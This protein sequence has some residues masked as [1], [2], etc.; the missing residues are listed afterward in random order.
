MVQICMLRLSLKIFLTFLALIFSAS[1]GLSAV[2]EC[3]FFAKTQPD[4]SSGLMTVDTIKGT[5]SISSSNAHVSD[6]AKGPHGVTID[7]KGTKIQWIMH[8]SKN[9]SGKTIHFT[10]QL[11]N[12]NGTT[13]AI[14]DLKST[15][16]WSAVNKINSGQCKLVKADVVGAVSI[17]TVTK[18]Q[19]PPEPKSLDGVYQCRFYNGWD[20]FNLRIRS[21][22]T[23]ST[24]RV[25]TKSKIVQILSGT[26]YKTE[27]ATS[28]YRAKVSNSGL[29][30]EWEFSHDISAYGT[31]RFKLN[32]GSLTSDTRSK[33]SV[34]PGQWVKNHATQGVK[35]TGE[36][37][38]LQPSVVTAVAT[39]SEAETP[40]PNTPDS[41]EA[42]FLTQQAFDRRN[43]QLILSDLSFYKS[44]IDGLYGSGT[45]SALYA[46]NDEYFRGSD[47]TK[48]DNVSALF[49]DILSQRVVEVEEPA[50]LDNLIEQI[51]D[52][53]GGELEPGE[54]ELSN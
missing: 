13:K 39:P 36:C 3:R 52:I 44:A 10:L 26:K 49:E 32:L 25:D 41:L 48:A 14:L 47:L 33:L 5:V 28:P 42:G 23:N 35:A 17:P 15:G 27:I 12:K 51:D 18:T 30:F 8:G 6:E 53:V 54:V 22:Y 7:D 9:S 16:F 4:Y 20:P 38:L 21:P 34:L 50:S 19:K 46:Y 29:T 1:V 40:T 11:N 43:I 2:Y 45:E 37:K 31:R 24:I